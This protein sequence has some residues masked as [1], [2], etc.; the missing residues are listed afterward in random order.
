MFPQR[1]TRRWLGGGSCTVD[2]GGLS[3]GGEGRGSSLAE[4]KCA[5]EWRKKALGKTC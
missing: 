3:V 4:E 1:A 5:E 2:H